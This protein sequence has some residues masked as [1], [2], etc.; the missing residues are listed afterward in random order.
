MNPI[1]FHNSQRQLTA[2]YPYTIITCQSDRAADG[3]LAG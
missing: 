1:K 3:G 2:S